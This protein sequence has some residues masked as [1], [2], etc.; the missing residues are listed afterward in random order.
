[1]DGSL[2]VIFIKER[3]QTDRAVSV[4]E[5]FFH[6]RDE[7]LLHKRNWGVNLDEFL[8]SGSEIGLFFFFLSFDLFENL[9]QLWVLL[10]VKLRFHLNSFDCRSVVHGLDS[11]NRRLSW[12]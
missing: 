6:L 3:H 5:D 8:G 9:T 10:N 11:A 2:F 4:S 7:F 12:L 1:M